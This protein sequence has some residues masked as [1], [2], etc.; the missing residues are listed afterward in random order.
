MNC[1]TARFERVG[2]GTLR[3]SYSRQFNASASLKKEFEGVATIN[4]EFDSSAS[5]NRVFVCRVGFICTT[6]LGQEDVLW[7][8]DG[9][10]F[11]VYGKKIYIT[12]KS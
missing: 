12:I 3:A 2:G 11:N 8:S 7:A 9:M 4:R 5:V 10:V 6:S 1:L